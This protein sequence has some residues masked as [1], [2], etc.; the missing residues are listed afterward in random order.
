MS[1]IQ[2]QSG[3]HWDA[4]RI[5]ALKFVS[6][7]FVLLI[8]PLDYK[9]YIY[10]F[11][12]SWLDFHITDL[13]RIVSYLP[14]FFHEIN[15]EGHL[16]VDGFYS[17]GLTVILAA[18]GVFLW[19]ALEK[20]Q[21]PA[22]R[23]YDRVYYWIRVLI[24]Y[25]LAFIL[26]AFGSIKAFPLQFPFP[27]LSNLHTNYGDFLP[28]K[29]WAHTVGVAP[30]YEAFL[31]VAELLAGVLL[32]WRRTVTFGAA[33]TMG[34]LTNVVYSSFSFQMGNQVLST[35]VFLSALFLFAHDGFRL[36]VLLFRQQPTVAE[37][38]DPKLPIQVSILSK[39]LTAVL[40]LVVFL[41][42][43]FNYKHDPYLIPKTAGLKNSFGFYNV[44]QFIFNNDTIPYSRTDSVRW[45]N[46]VF[47][48]WATI[49]IKTARP[50]KVD[51]KLYLTSELTDIDRVYES[52]GVGDRRYYK[53]V[54][55]SAASS[56]ELL[57]KN[58]N[59]RGESYRLKFSRPDENTIIL[60]GVSNKND[61]ITAVLEKIDRKYMLIESRRF[62][63]QL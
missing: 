2:S 20:T 10:L 5:L 59:Y 50:V 39:G 1:N 29:I 40:I 56:L 57:N 52:A 13:V 18:A 14:A 8:I 26:I 23:D 42:A 49:S 51:P 17:W 21:L 12:G 30:N 24:R 48:Q 45:Q 46:V 35:F 60:K 6:L 7:F 58:V 25:K 32:L 43:L 16:A 62:P 37:T 55:D 44:R 3:L 53:Y 27:S 19:N 41:S 33:L 9:F 15:S 11:S 38:Y 22:L 34:I 63:I 31:G 4:N 36:Y 61:S 47:E 28:W 54:I